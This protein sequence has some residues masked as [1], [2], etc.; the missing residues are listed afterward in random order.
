MIALRPEGAGAV[1]AGRAPSEV[2]GDAALTALYRQLDYFPTPPWAARA[3]GELIRF[4][5]PLARTLW[6]PACGEGHM[7]AA[8]GEAFAVYSSDIHP[9][10]YG[11]TIDFLSEAAAVPHCGAEGPILPDWIVTNPPFR[12]AADFLRLGLSRSRRGVALLLRLQFL[13]GAARYRLL[14]GAEPLSVCAVFSERVPMTLGRWDPAASTATGYAWLLWRKGQPGP[15]QLRG[16]PPGTRARL[17]LPG[18]AP[19]FGFRC[20]AGLLEAM[21]G[22]NDAKEAAE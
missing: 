22:G 11:D 7:A 4:I 10:G 20:E 18:D 13:E 6:E 3:G 8:L 15:P 19:R 17:T 16:I 12:T 21:G 14:H 5:D 1:M 9:F 2:E